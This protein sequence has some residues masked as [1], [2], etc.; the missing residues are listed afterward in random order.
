MNQVG[1]NFDQKNLVNRSGFDNLLQDEVFI[2]YLNKFCFQNYNVII[3]V[4]FRVLE[5]AYGRNYITIK[6]WTSHQIRYEKSEKSKIK[7][8]QFIVLYNF[9]SILKFMALPVFGQRL[10]YRKGQGSNMV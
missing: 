9:E 2:D 10:I 6:V 5:K 8:D 3:Y 7:L 1:Q 4:R